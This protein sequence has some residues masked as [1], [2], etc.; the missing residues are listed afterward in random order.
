[1]KIQRYPTIKKWACRVVATII[2]LCVA[3]PGFAARNVILVIGDGM[4]DNQIA[5]A[6]NQLLGATG[7]L[8][9]DRMPQRGVSQ[10]LTVD[11][12]KLSRPIYVADSANTA[13]AMATGVVTSIGRVGTAPNTGK[14]LQ[15]LV[16]LAKAAG[17]RAG[18]VSTSSLTDATPAAFVAHAAK[19]KCQGPTDMERPQCEIDRKHAGGLG[20]IATQIAESNIDVLI[21]G[22]LR[23]FTQTAENAPTPLS[24]AVE[25]GFRYASDYEQI[26]S[27]DNGTRMLALLADDLLSVRMMGEEGRAAERWSED[28]TRYPDAFRCVSNPKAANTPALADLT[29]QAIRLLANANGFF[30]M[31]E[32]AIIDKAAHIR[33]PC[34]SIGEV[35][36]LDES[37]SVALQFA[38]DNP[39][40]LVLVTADH[41]HAAQIVPAYNWFADAGFHHN[42]GWYA[43]LRTSEG[44]VMGVGYSSSTAVAAETHTGV[45]VPVYAN[46]PDGFNLPTHIRQS[47]I[48]SLMR[49]YLGL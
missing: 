49:D 41:G 8:Q 30:L 14:P 38:K 16:D 44:G 23:Y 3:A 46:A 35:Q 20:P 32:S 26:A 27:A 6:R 28:A 12:S 4:D 17:M 33:N 2:L 29:Q 37:V 19:R 43:P 48:F 34:V 25:N 21:G 10:V 1:M 7:Q 42:F 15:T 36:Q 5:I 22:G 24:V 39:D 18:I 31:V 9:L 11:D 40:T 13:T 47:Q 45:H